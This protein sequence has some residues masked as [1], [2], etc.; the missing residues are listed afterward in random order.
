MSAEAGE[1]QPRVE[2][3]KRGYGWVIAP[4][5]IFVGMTL[6]FGYALKTGDPSRLPSALIGKVAPQYDFPPLEGLVA[7][8]KPVPGLPPG[9]LTAGEVTVVNF[10]ASWCVPCRTEH[11]LLEY[12]KRET[13]VRLVGVNY[14]DPAP[15]GTKFLGQLGNPFDAVGT[16]GSGR[17]AIEWGV[18]GM[19]ETFVLDGKGRIVYKHVGPISESSLRDQVMPAIERARKMNGG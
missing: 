12:L 6:M 19:P 17:G 10:F 15:G 1:P 7:G 16:D 3:S 4:L 9:G 11:P 5:V 8:G 2:K 18:Y 14:K 13:G